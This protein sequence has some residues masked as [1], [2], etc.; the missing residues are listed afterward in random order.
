MEVYSI[1]NTFI[2]D[3]LNR[4]SVY[5]TIAPNHTADAPKGSSDNTD[6]VTLSRDGRARG[7]HLATSVA[8]QESV[9]NEGSESLS[10]QEMVQLRQLK[11]RDS[12]VR[13]HEQAHLSAA[14]QYARGGASFTYQKGP[15][16]SSYAIGGEVGIDVSKES[17]PSATIAKMQTIKR[18]ALAPANPSG[19]DKRI[20]AQATIQENKARQELLEDRQEELLSAEYNESRPLDPKSI[21]EKNESAIEPSSYAGLKTKFAV[22]EKIAQY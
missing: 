6:T 4:S 14:G 12:E 19:A 15:D 5:G 9:N 1:R 13:S 22:Y 2:N 16:G 11:Q 20:A 18:A 21:S 17:S 3:G 8:D 10:Q 7:S